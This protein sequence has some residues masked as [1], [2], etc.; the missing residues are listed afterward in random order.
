VLSFAVAGGIFL[1]ILLAGKP[2]DE[3]EEQRPGRPEEV[4]T[5][6]GPWALSIKS[7]TPLDSRLDKDARVRLATLTTPILPVTGTV[8]ASLK[9]GAEEAKDTWQFA[10]GDLL[11]AFADWQRAVT[12]V[13]FQ[14]K[15]LELITEMNNKRVKRQEEVVARKKELLEIGTETKEV[16]AAE[17]TNLI[18]FEIQKRK[19]IH[20][21]ETQVKLAERNEA[22]LARQLQQ[23]GLEPTMLRSAATEGLIVVAE[24]PERMIRVV[25]VGMDC[26]VEFFALPDHKPPFT[27]KVSSI[28]PVVSKDKRVANVQFV[29]A[30]PT[31]ELRPGMFARIG[32][33]DKREALV[34]P[35]DGV[36]HVGD[37]EYA[38]VG[39]KEGRWQ[40]FQ[41]E[42][43]ELLKNPFDLLPGDLVRNDIEVL[44]GYSLADPGRRLQKDDRVIGQGAILLQ[45]MVI[46]ALQVPLQAPLAK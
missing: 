2:A 12:D 16:L 44:S 24:V 33:G 13:K 28:S 38:L 4:V 46:R 22:T 15:Q 42:T 8:L 27:G 6:A 41:V 3:G 31:R 9:P 30:D 5:I 7:G 34:M 45:P 18:A 21:Q 10:S 29:V 14:K 1:F 32:L 19:E 35:A 23:N 36:V 37:H 40:I 25:K 43:G 11:S 17:E 20:E 26:T 39:T